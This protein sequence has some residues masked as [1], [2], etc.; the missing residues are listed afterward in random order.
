MENEND[1][2]SGAGR[3]KFTD[4]YRWRP[5]LSSENLITLFD[6]R[7]GGLGWSDDAI[8][9]LLTLSKSRVFDKSL[10]SFF[11]THSHLLCYIVSDNQGK[12][13]VTQLKHALYSWVATDVINIEEWRWT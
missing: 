9:L 10:L 12:W 4:D 11:T 6:D 7:C 5:L 2:M 8:E 3:Y 1:N 13:E